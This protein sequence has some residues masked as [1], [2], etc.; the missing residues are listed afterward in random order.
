MT[1]KDNGDGTFTLIPTTWFQNDVWTVC[2]N[3]GQ[4]VTG[5]SIHNCLSQLKPLTDDEIMNIGDKYLLS[6]FVPI[7]AL[8]FARAIEKSHG[9][10]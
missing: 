10:E 1:I 5:D 7:E 2:R 4:R 9:I 6:A 8:K 3:C